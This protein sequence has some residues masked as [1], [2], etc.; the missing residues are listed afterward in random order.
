[1]QLGCRPCC[2]VCALLQLQQRQA[3]E[4]AEDSLEAGTGPGDTGGVD[5]DVNEGQVESLSLGQGTPLEAEVLE[6]D[7]WELAG[8]YAASFRVKEIRFGPH[9]PP[10]LKAAWRGLGEM[11]SP[12]LVG[13]PGL[14]RCLLPVTA[15]LSLSEHFF[16]TPFKILPTVQP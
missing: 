6:P 13:I 9:A 16:L 11:P 5:G 3:E 12:H 1:M 10:W 15:R 14:Q 8:R 7:P 2:S 4:D